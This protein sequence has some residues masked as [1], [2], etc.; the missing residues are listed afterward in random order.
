MALALLPIAVALEAMSS[1]FAAMSS[2]FLAMV[3]AYAEMFP[4]STVTLFCRALTA[5]PLSDIAD[6]FA[7]I[8]RLFSAIS[9]SQTLI[10]EAFAEIVRA[11]AAIYSAFA[12]YQCLV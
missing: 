11:F 6:S 8:R 12:V 1:A 4:S 5:A 2:A 7:W 3:E 10:S 9:C